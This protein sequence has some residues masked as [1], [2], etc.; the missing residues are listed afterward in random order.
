MPVYD[1]VGM[2]ARVTSMYD[3]SVEV[4]ADSFAGR[5]ISGTAMLHGDNLHWITTCTDSG[6]WEAGDGIRKVGDDGG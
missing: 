6:K 2:S 1:Y 4:L 5:T 3:S